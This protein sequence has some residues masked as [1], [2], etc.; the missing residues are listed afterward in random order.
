MKKIILI[1]DS[2]RQGYDKYVKEALAGTAEVYYTPDNA[3]FAQYT[4]RY[5]HEWRDQ[6]KWPEDVDLIHWNTGLWDALELFSDGPMG[7]LDF[8]SHMI[9]R[10]HK[11]LK[12]LFTKAKQIF[13]TSTAVEERMFETPEIFGRHN[14]VIEDFN[15]AALAALA[16]TDVIVNDLYALTRNCPT[17]WHSD[18]V[19]Y[20]TDIGRAQIGGQVLA[21]VCK[22]LG[23]QARDVNLENFE[24]EKYTAAMIGM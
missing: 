17:V 18:A 13:A 1:G 23:I 24:P 19:H 11:R 16:G 22:E 14:S 12:L 4:L 10:I 7:E 15:R 21:A 3:R 8:Y 6:E 5:L 2:I 9:P 20:Y